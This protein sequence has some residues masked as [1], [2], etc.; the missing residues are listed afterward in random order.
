MSSKVKIPVTL[1]DFKDRYV[2]KYWSPVKALELPEDDLKS[3]PHNE[4]I[5]HEE[6][7]S[8]NLE[9]ILYLDHVKIFDLFEYVEIAY[10]DLDITYTLRLCNPSFQQIIGF[11]KK[12]KQVFGEARYE[13][14]EEFFGNENVLKEA[15]L[16]YSGSVSK[17]FRSTWLLSEKDYRF[18]SMEISWEADPVLVLEIPCNAPE[19]DYS[20]RKNGT[21]LDVLEY[22][23]VDLLLDPQLRSHY[24]ESE[25][26]CVVQGW[27]I[28]PRLWDI[29]SRLD[30][31]Q[32]GKELDPSFSTRT[33]FRFY[34]RRELDVS[35]VFKLIDKLV[36]IYGADD[37]GKKWANEADA[38]WYI[39]DEMG[40]ARYWT[41]NQFHGLYNNYVEGQEKVYQVSVFA[42][43]PEEEVCLR[44]TNYD[45]LLQYFV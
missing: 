36:A 1:Q 22:N 7:T 20:V 40:A 26:Y 32:H 45:K 14:E 18:I 38:D 29:F 3:L 16:S 12:M 41:F 13:D 8:R 4:L 30:F 34:T 43:E 39:Y 6:Y 17:G 21:I 27:H 23:F 5:I 11:Y 42:S 35:E 2:N 25:D 28:R 15:L 19:V 10:G 44:V 24:I 33:D 9:Q 31:T 37:E